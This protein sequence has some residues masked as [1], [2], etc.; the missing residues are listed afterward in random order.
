MAGSIYSLPSLR[1]IKGIPIKVHTIKSTKINTEKFQRPENQDEVL[2]LESKGEK[3]NEKFFLSRKINFFSSEFFGVGKKKKKK[4]FLYSIKKK[5]FSYDEDS[6]LSRPGN[7]GQSG[8]TLART[9]PRIFMEYS[10]NSVT[11][12]PQLLL[13][14]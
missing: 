13:N 6:S 7:K 8:S 14:I 4:I 2:F 5:I 3:K 11:K 12:S 9:P 1:A 10:S